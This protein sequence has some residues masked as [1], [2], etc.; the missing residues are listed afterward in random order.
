MRKVLIA[1]FVLLAAPLSA[2]PT[3]VQAANGHNFVA[4]ASFALTAYS[5]NVTTGNRLIVWFSENGG[6]SC[7]HGAPT[8]TEGNTYTQIGT[9]E[10]GIVRRLSLWTS[11]NVTGGSSFVV[12]L[13]CSSGTMTWVGGVTV[14]IADS[15][16]YN[17]DFVKGSVSGVSGEFGPTTTVEA[18]ANSLAV[19]GAATTCGSDTVTNGTDWLSVTNERQVNNASQDLYGEHKVESSTYTATW[20]SSGTCDKAFITASFAPVDSPTSNDYFTFALML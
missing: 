13:N 4:A 10:T 3:A 15:G 11:Q 20:S 19:A 17:E 1:L 7:V 14:E 6:G 9:T 12:T 2:Q 8:D 5:S 16:D 18:V